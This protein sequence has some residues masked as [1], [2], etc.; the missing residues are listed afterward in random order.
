MD[1]L[2]NNNVIIGELNLPLPQL[3][4]FLRANINSK[5]DELMDYQCM[6]LI[7][8]MPAM[9][10][11]DKPKVDQE[12]K[13]ILR[14]TTA[15]HFVAR[16]DLPMGSRKIRALFQ[17]Y[18][19]FEA[20]YADETGLS[21]LH[22]ACRY[23]FDDIVEKFIEA[24]HSP[25]FRPLKTVDPPLH[26]A[27]CHGHWKTAEFLLSRGGA[28]PNA[29]SRDELT[30]LHVLSQKHKCDTALAQTLL[31]GSVGVRVDAWDKLGNT[32][33]HLAL[34]WGNTEMAK[35]LLRCGANPNFVN[36]AGMS[37]LH[38]ISRR[39]RHGNL[40]ELFFDVVDEMQ[41]TVQVDDAWDK[42]GN[43]PLH[44][45]LQQRLKRVT[46][47]LLRRGADPNLACAR[48]WQLS[49]HLLPAAMRRRAHR[50]VL[51]SRQ[52][53]TPPDGE[54]DFTPTS[55]IQDEKIETFYLP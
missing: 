1:Q 33:L 41:L 27:L 37:P 47:L 36:S 25:N 44:Y 34:H 17:V 20:N 30:A 6:S 42:K 28:D 51:P 38:V 31:Y 7:E 26:L 46:E 12:G 19:K 13:L 22:V 5:K 14:R 3:E 21:H 24:G 8:R 16:R 55:Q 15:I 2:S 29:T 23:G 4:E 10:F 53:E 54:N 49:A 35:L 18:N 40:A 32:P 48:R 11:K 9:K 50:R 43:T 45:A 52:R 39:D